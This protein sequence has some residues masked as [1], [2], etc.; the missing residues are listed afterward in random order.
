M[1]VL[2][3]RSSNTALIGDQLL[4]D[5]FGAN[6]LGIYTILVDPI[7]GAETGFFR[8]IMRWIEQMIFPRVSLKL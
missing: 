6:L 7:T 4:T 1:W 3:S 2:K 5:I 8:R